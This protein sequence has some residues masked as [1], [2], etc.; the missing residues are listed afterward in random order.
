[1]RAELSDHRLAARGGAQTKRPDACE[2]ARAVTVPQILRALG[3]RVRNRKRADCPLCKGSSKETLAFTESVWK[4]HRCNAGGN[5]FS[6]VQAV[7]RCDFLDSLRY[8][9]ELAGIRLEDFRGAHL[10]R[11]LA[12]H[13]R[14][15]DRI[16]NAAE[17]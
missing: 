4:C 9:A 10:H 12:E 5:V 13:K 2:I 16:E 11:E 14:K 17:T 1:M 6:L 8:V 3:A 15:R 7:K